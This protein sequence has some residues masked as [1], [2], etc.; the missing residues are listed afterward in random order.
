[1]EGAHE[2]HRERMAEME[3]VEP[4]KSHKG[5]GNRTLRR[6]SNCSRDFFSKIMIK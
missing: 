6:V 1:M 4:R 3:G 2:R 5:E